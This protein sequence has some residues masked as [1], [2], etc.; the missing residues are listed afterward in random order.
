M[1]DADGRARQGQPH[2][3]APRRGRLASS[4][5]AGL[6]PEPRGESLAWLG[7]R[8]SYLDAHV[9]SATSAG[10]VDG[11]DARPHAAAVRRARRPA[12]RV[13]GRPH[14][15]H[16]RQG[17]G[18]PDGHR[19]LLG[20]HGLTVGTYTSPHLER[21]NERISP[22]RRADRRRRPGRASSPTSPASSRS[23]DVRAVV[24]RAAGRRGVPLVRR[25]G[26]RRRRG[27]GRPARPVGRHQRGRRRGGGAHQRRA[28]PHRR[29]RATGAAH[30]RRRRRASS[31]RARTFVLGETDPE[32]ADVFAATPAAVDAGAADDDFGCTSNRLAVGGRRARPAHARRPPTRTCSC[33]CTARTRATTPRSRW[34]PPRRSSTGRSTADVVA[35]AFADGA[36][37]GPVR[38]RRPR[39]AR[40]PRR[41]PQPDGRRG[42]RRDARRGVHH[43]RAAPARGRRAGRARPARA[44]RP[45][46]ERRPRRTRCVCCTPDSPRA[47]PAA[48]LAAVV[49]EL[50]GRAARRCPTVA[51]GGRRPRS[52]R[53]SPTTSCWSPARSTWS[54]PA[55]TACRTIRG[56]QVAG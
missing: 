18:G 31:S 42:R 10:R 14:H 36:H 33:R 52:P 37:A 51:R 53:P 1:I 11:P 23:L 3:R 48:E 8:A 27:R 40:G 20:H 19:P 6:R 4:A 28:R 21:I 39:A 38:D 25:G 50:G 35:E 46:L 54:A 44:A 47:L 5:R 2:A 30:R 56:L 41:R 49:T 34:P 22:Q 16:Q 7:R 13:A 24:L 26:R 15:R 32:L 45:L 12:G 17:L 29:R 43:R 9:T 55:R